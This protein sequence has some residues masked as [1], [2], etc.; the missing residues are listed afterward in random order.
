MNFKKFH[1]SKNLFP[2]DINKLYVGRIENNGMIDYQV[3]TITIDGSSITYQADATWRG[4]YTDYIQVADSVKLTITPNVKNVVSWACSCYDTNNNFLGEATSTSTS[5][6]SAKTFTL[7]EGTTKVRISITSENKSYT[8]QNPMLNTGST[9]LPYEPYNSEVWHDIPYYQHKTATDTL[10]LPAVIYPNDTSITVG[11]KG[12]TTQSGTPS[13]QNPVVI[14]GTGDMSGNLINVQPF[15]IEGDSTSHHIVLWSGTLPVGTYTIHLNQ[16]N[17]LTTALRNT[18]RLTIGGTDYFESTN[19]NYHLQS[20]QHKMIFSVSDA[21]QTIEIRYWGNALSNDCSYSNIMLNTG[22]TALPYEPYGYKIP[23][24]SAGQTNNIYL[25]EVETTRRVKKLVLTGKEG[26]IYSNPAIET[27]NAFYMIRTD[28]LDGA[29][30]GFCTHYPTVSQTSA[31]EGVYFGKNIS[32]FTKFSDGI[33]TVEKLKAYFATQYANGTPVTIW[34][35]LKNETTAT[36][37]EPLMK[38]GTYTDTLTTSIPCTAG[39]NTLDV[40]TTVQPSEVSAGFSGWH[41]VSGV[42]E[43]SGNYTI[44]TMQALTIAQLQTHTI[45]DL[46]GGEWS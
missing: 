14:N 33:D 27:S 3:G 2:L 30:Q 46:Q 42:H 45:S 21:T 36:V 34:Y 41:P 31:V 37:N 32:V 7:I 6:A 22:S 15:T 13:P 24:L 12:N 10:T 4:F 25:G 5:S 26:Q 9:A 1:E 39:E 8:I 28:C 43:F 11:I 23:I 35:V 44:A 40:Q 19:E 38:I 16:D 20:G 17:A 18:I 29:L